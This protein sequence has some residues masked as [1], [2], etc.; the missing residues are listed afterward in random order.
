M[1]VVADTNVLL[2]VIVYDEPRQARTAEHAIQSAEFVAITSATFCELGW[3][4]SSVY[5]YSRNEIAKTFRGFLDAENVLMDRASAEAGLAMLD[6]G[7]D[8]ADGVIAFEGRRLG[9]ETFVSFD[10]QAVRLLKA[11]GA[12]ARLLQPS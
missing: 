7:G 5:G 8:F 6:A 2:R 11:A 1:R 9:S 3:V 10:R 4:L 12:E